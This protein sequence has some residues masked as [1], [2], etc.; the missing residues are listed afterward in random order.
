MKKL[1]ALIASLILLSLSTATAAELPG[2]ETKVSAGYSSHG[3]DFGKITA[4]GTYLAGADITWQS[5]RLSALT[6]N[7]LSFGSNST[8]KFNRLDLTGG[9]KLFSSLADVELG[10][11]LHYLYT[12]PRFDT[13]LHWQPF[14]SISK[15]RFSVTGAFDL[16]SRTTN[17]EADV[18]GPSFKVL[19]G[20]VVTGAFAGYSDV[21]DALPKTLKEIK[22][23]NA[24]FGG[25]VDFVYKWFRVGGFALHDGHKKDTTF[26]WRTFATYKF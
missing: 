4:G 8:F 22:Y 26:G 5:F 9:Y 15:S 19:G 1:N 6:H 10:T 12:T 17:I 18:K 20:K 23:T 14:V 2:L 3:V 7:D 11:T 24:Y 21:N 16:A 25:S 13:D